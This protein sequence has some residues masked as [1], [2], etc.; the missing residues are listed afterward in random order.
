ME[1]WGTYIVLLSYQLLYIINAFQLDIP[2]NFYGS[3]E[4][5]SG[6]LSNN[7]VFIEAFTLHDDHLSMSG[8]TT[9]VTNALENFDTLGK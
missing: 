7:E 5:F 1:F 9:E 3:S 2:S 4:V 6:Y 8:S